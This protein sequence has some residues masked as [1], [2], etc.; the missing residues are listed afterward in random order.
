MAAPGRYRSRFC[1]KCFDHD[2]FEFSHS[3]GSGWVRAA[4]SHTVDPMTPDLSDMQ[5]GPTGYPRGGTDLLIGQMK[6]D[7]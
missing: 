7:K 1:S 5:Y 6:N 3:L 4:E 2:Q